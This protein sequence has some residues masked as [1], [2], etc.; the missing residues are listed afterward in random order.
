MAVRLAM[1][2]S[3][4]ELSESSHYIHFGTQKSIPKSEDVSVFLDEVERRDLG[5]HNVPAKN[6]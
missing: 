3:L 5:L 4:E 6:S 2:A 1:R